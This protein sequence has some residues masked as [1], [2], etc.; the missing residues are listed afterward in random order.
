MANDL[1]PSSL[2]DLRQFAPAKPMALPG[3]PTVWSN[4]LIQRKYDGQRLYVFV[5]AERT[6]HLISRGGHNMTAHLPLLAAQIRGWNLPAKTLLDGEFIVSMQGIDNFLATGSILRSLPERAATMERLHSVRYVVF[7]VLFYNG[8]VVWQRTYRDRW[9]LLEKLVHQGHSR[10]VV[11]VS[12]PEVIPAQSPLTSWNALKALVTTNRWEG[13]IFW[14]LHW[15]TV[16]R[17]DGHPARA[18]CYRWKPVLDDDFIVTGYTPG[19]GKHTGR[20]GALVLAQYVGTQLVDMG[21]VGTGFDDQTRV[22]A[23]QW[24]YPL[25]A[26]VEFGERT[27]NGKLRFPRF[28]GLRPDK[29]PEECVWTP[30]TSSPSL[31]LSPSS[32]GSLGD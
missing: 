32:A 22:E 23:C 17:F 30:S 4:Y 11:S 7:D 8:H 18:N 2:D 16:V 31:L 10:G 29:P 12:L 24:T 9:W 3:V 20:M 6:T 14:Q 19:Q 21:T 1:I 15:P 27:P 25:V 13:L 26:R 28:L 5:D